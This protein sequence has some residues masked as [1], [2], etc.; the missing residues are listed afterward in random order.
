M[1]YTAIS[2]FSVCG[3]DVF[4]DDVHGYEAVALAVVG[5]VARFGSDA[6]DDILPLE[7]RWIRLY[8]QQPACRASLE[9]RAGGFVI[10][11]VRTIG[12]G[13][14]LGEEDDQLIPPP[15]AMRGRSASRPPR[16]RR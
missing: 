9:I 15:R 6:R 3:C 16:W 13:E 5:D 12:S 4:G 14:A 2:L 10:L 8:E 1:R 7:R 11:I